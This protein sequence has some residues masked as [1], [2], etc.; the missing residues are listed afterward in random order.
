M[1]THNQVVHIALSTDTDAFGAAG[2]GNNTPVGVRQSFVRMYDI[3]GGKRYWPVAR[4]A[5]R[6]SHAV[7]VCYDA[8][9]RES[10]A[11]AAVLFAEVAS[12]ADVRSTLR[13][14]CGV[15]P[16]SSTR[17][18]HSHHHPTATATATMTT[19]DPD[20]ALA[21]VGGSSSSS[22]ASLVVRAADAIDALEGLVQCVFARSLRG[23]IGREGSGL[24]VPTV[25]DVLC[26]DQQDMVQ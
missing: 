18:G 7:V 17:G 3:A 4:L 6:S 13:I 2:A 1:T 11:R 26:A 16:R 8:T 20:A 23:D 9:S 5:A 22:A 12:V 10:L 15:L 21:F 14:L 25:L 19:I 24:A